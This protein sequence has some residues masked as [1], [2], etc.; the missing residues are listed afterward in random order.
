MYL[1][2]YKDITR[3]IVTLQEAIWDRPSPEST[4]IRRLLDGLGQTQRMRLESE[5]IM[6]RSPF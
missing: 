5:V 1:G 6:D 2:L 4:W 3:Y